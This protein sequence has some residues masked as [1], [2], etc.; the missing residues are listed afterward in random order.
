MVL[1]LFLTSLSSHYFWL[2][3][4]LYVTGDYDFFMAEM[5]SALKKAVYYGNPTEKVRI[6]LLSVDKY[7]SHD[8]KTSSLVEIFANSKRCCTYY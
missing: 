2:K 5:A 4:V 7:S 8:P 6:S 1:D 3:Q